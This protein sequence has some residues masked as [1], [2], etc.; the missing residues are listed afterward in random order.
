MWPQA[1]SCMPDVFIEF[2]D[3]QNNSLDSPPS[4]MFNNQE[5]SRGSHVG[6][7]PSQGGFRGKR[8]RSQCHAD[9]FAIYTLRLIQRRCWYNRSNEQK[10]EN[11]YSK[12]SVD[13]SSWPT[14]I[15]D[16]WFLMSFQADVNKH[17]HI[18]PNRKLLNEKILLYANLWGIIQMQH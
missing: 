1:D 11:P 12:G 17:R 5:C 16:A 3:H 18:L 15:N 9:V 6:W 10:Q 8:P 13:A 4:S 7:L 14:D 2:L